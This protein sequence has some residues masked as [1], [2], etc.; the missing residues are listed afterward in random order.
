MAETN[1]WELSEAK[2]QVTISQGATPWHVYLTQ[3]IPSVNTQLGQSPLEADGDFILATVL[4]NNIFKPSRMSIYPTLFTYRI[5]WLFSLVW[6]QQLDTE[7]K[8][9]AQLFRTVNEEKILNNLTPEELQALTQLSENFSEEEIKELRRNETM[10]VADLEQTLTSAYNLASYFQAP[11]KPQIGLERLSIQKLYLPTNRYLTDMMLAACLFRQLESLTSLP[12]SAFQ[13]FSKRHIEKVKELTSRYSNGLR[14]ND[15]SFTS[16]VLQDSVEWLKLDEEQRESTSFI[17]LFN[18][19]G[20]QIDQIVAESIGGK[21]VSTNDSVE[22]QSEYGTITL[23]SKHTSI[24]IGTSFVDA[25]KLLSDEPEI[26]RQLVSSVSTWLTTNQPVKYYS[27]LTK[28]DFQQRLA[29][30]ATNQANAI[31]ALIIDSTIPKKLMNSER[32]LFRRLVRST[33]GV[34]TFGALS[35]TT[36][37]P[38]NIQPVSQRL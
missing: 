13:L 7:S 3:P 19:L 17:K 8:T 24:T 36:K 5:D 15:R 29:A 33:D 18:E 32:Q 14:T 10:S 35:G 22:I 26:R 21:I 25:Y 28:T 2:A 27:P 11:F 31:V 37:H 34:A 38:V 6:N 9:I 1:D 30:Y 23:S 12:P 4:L 16:R 20:K